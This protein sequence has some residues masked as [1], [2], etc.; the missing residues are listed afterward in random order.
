MIRNDTINTITFCIIPE[1][2]SAFAVFAKRATI[3]TKKF[4][5][6]VS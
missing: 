2:N 4:Y 3:Y 1:K 5:I 6:C